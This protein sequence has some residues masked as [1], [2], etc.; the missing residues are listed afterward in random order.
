MFQI[1]CFFCLILLVE[2]FPDPGKRL[3]DK[4]AEIAAKGN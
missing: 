3:A 1:Q 2:A 4:L